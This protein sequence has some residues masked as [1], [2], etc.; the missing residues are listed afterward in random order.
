MV[1]LQGPVSRRGGPAQAPSCPFL[2]LGPVGSRMPDRIR[3]PWLPSDWVGSVHITRSTPVRAFFLRSLPRAA[4]GRLGLLSS[5]A[6]G[7]ANGRSSGHASGSKREGPFRSCCGVS[8]TSR[9]RGIITPAG[10]RVVGISSDA[11]TRR[12]GGRSKPT[13]T[14]SKRRQGRRL[15]AGGFRVDRAIDDNQDGSRRTPPLPLTASSHGFGCSCNM[16]ASKQPRPCVGG[17]PVLDRPA[18]RICP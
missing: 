15:G 6:G 13:T 2:D 1:A 11:A 18:P 14:T 3:C 16:H 7:E 17:D 5:T 4:G 10:H 8:I 9:T 12:P